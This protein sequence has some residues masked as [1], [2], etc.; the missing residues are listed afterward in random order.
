M[1]LFFVAWHYQG[2]PSSSPQL[3]ASHK[4]SPY[5]LKRADSASMKL[6]V[7]CPSWFFLLGMHTECPEGHHPCGDNEL[8]NQTLKMAE[9]RA[10]KSQVPDY[11]M[12]L[13]SQ[14]QPGRPQNCS[15]QEK[16]L[17]FGR[18]TEGEALCYTQP[19]VAPTWHGVE[20]HCEM[21]PIQLC[22][23]KG[24]R[25]AWELNHSV[26]GSGLLWGR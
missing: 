18:A 10:R 20:Q 8:E 19:K 11:T 14:P 6:V 23:V 24:Q 1:L 2:K 13:L 26:R 17:P 3:R 9:Q 12:E 21:L 16:H 7:F 25:G 4:A 22:V 15:W 5:G